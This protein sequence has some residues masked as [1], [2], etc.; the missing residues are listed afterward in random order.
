MLWAEFIQKLT[1][2]TAVTL[3]GPL[4]DKLHLPK[5]PTIYV[6][7][8]HHFRPAKSEI[9]T[10]TSVGDGDSTNENDPLDL[11]LPADKDFSDLSFALRALPPAISEIELLGFLG[12]RRDHELA[13][14]GEI[15][16]HLSIAKTKAR[17]HARFE[18]STA[19]ESRQRVLALSPGDW[20][21][22]ASGEFSIFVLTHGEIEIEGD[23]RYPYKGEF[24][25]LSSHG[26]SNVASG[27]LI[28]R[29]PQVPLFVI[30]E[31][32]QNPH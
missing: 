5:N 25:T 31:S 9:E 14:L 23:C 10:I 30:G 27:T 29:S 7:G 24:K 16:N 15:H 19:N 6:D 8:G 1:S 11:L 32:V 3:V 4:Y 12:G 2:E 26:L 28:V 20:K 17:R 13:N 21:V 22:N 18:P